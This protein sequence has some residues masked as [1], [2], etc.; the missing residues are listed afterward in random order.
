M[1]HPVYKYLFI[2]VPLFYLDE[3]RGRPKYFFSLSGN[4]GYQVNEERHS[5]CEVCGRKSSC[6]GRMSSA[7]TLT[8]QK[9]GFRFQ[10]NLL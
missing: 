5:S 3:I 9:D 2:K 4:G 1:G 10:V 6:P 7:K 8:I